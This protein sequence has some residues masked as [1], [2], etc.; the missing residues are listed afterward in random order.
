[1]NLNLCPPLNFNV[2]NKVELSYRSLS[3][4]S[5]LVHQQGFGL[6]AAK[7]SVFE[8]VDGLLHP[9]V[10]VGRDI[11]GRDGV[12]VEAAFCLSEVHLIVQLVRFDFSLLVFVE[13]F[14]ALALLP[15]TALGGLTWNAVGAEPVLLPAAPVA[16]VGAAIRPCVYSV[17]VFLVVFILAAVLTAILPGVDADAVHIVVDPLSFVLAAIEPCVRAEAL[18]LILLPVSI[19]LGAIVPAVEASAMLLSGQVLSFVD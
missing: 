12:Y 10:E 1:M 13:P 8:L 6:F 7:S 3:S 15:E 16:G 19:V 4:S 17:T 14:D 2:I 18:D 11:E 9:A 5:S